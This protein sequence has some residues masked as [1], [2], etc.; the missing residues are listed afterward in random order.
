[1]DVPNA[2]F[3]LGKSHL[4][5]AAN[6]LAEAF[7]SDPQIRIF[8]PEE[9]FRLEQSRSLFQFLLMYSV[10]NGEVYA[11]SSRIKA[12]AAWLQYRNTNMSFRK[13]VASGLLS[14]VCRLGFTT[15]R[16]IYCFNR[17]VTS[18]QKEFTSFEHYYLFLIAVHPNH[19]GEGLATALLRPI[20]ERLDSS[21]LPCCLATCNPSNVSFYEHFDFKVLKSTPVPGTDM[22]HYEMLR[23]PR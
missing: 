17:L 11:P 7:Y 4:Q 22:V 10:L 3:R 2:L 15:V 18:L 8:F 14:L 12:V 6:L 19:R 1:M 5:T 21:K 9:S 20:L 13:M 16:K 23:K